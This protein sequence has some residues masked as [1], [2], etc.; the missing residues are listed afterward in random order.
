MPSPHKLVLG[1]LALSPIGLLSNVDVGLITLAL[2]SVVALLILSLF[3][4][5]SEEPTRSKAPLWFIWSAHLLLLSGLYMAT[6][7]VANIVGSGRRSSARGAVSSLRMVGWAQRQ[8]VK[9]TQRTCSLKELNGQRPLKGF[10]PTLQRP[11]WR[12]LVS[13]PHGEVAQVGQYHYALYPAANLVGDQTG[14]ARG[15]VTRTHTRWI[16]YAWPRDDRTLQSYCVDDH[17]EI[18]ELPVSAEGSVYVGLDAA[19]SPGAC[20]GALHWDPEPPLTEA[21]MSAVAEQRKPPPSTHLGQ[22]QQTWRRWRG[23]RTRYA[24]S[25]DIRSQK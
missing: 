6:Y 7:G 19:P 24:R 25:L 20:L 16:A 1:A 11:Q 10:T 15:S 2:G 8:C 18:L 22:D 12:S 21:Q 13:G 14:E 23:K 5:S 9:H 3:R 4:G 17:E